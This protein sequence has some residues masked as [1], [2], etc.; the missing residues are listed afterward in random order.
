M[1]LLDWFD[2]PIGQPNGDVKEVITF[3]ALNSLEHLRA[4]NA[5]LGSITTEMGL[6]VRLW[7]ERENAYK[8][9]W[10]WKLI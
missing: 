7:R 8:E 10:N 3:P 6:K 2:M 1:F 4:R 5:I 9:Q